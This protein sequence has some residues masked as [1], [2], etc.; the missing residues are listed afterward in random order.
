MEKVNV[1]TKL[2]HKA[3]VFHRDLKEENILIDLDTGT[4]KIIDFGCGDLL[5]HKGTYTEYEGT[6]EFFPPEWIKYGEYG[7]VRDISKQN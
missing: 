6:R 1:T 7:G 4:T 3:G 5:M 2:C